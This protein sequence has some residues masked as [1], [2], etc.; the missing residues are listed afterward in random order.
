MLTILLVFL[1]HAWDLA[2]LDAVNSVEFDT[3][4]ESISETG[5]IYNSNELPTVYLSRNKKKSNICN[6]HWKKCQQQIS[7]KVI[8]FSVRELDCVANNLLMYFNFWLTA[9]IFFYLFKIKL[10]TF[11]LPGGKVSR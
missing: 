6:K 4:R 5:K 3:S 2:I 9:R 10:N 7:C 8:F 1:F 11:M